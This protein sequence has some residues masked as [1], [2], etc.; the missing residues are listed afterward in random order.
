M[1]NELAL[2]YAYP[3]MRLEK[4]ADIRVEKAR[5]RIGVYVN[6]DALQISDLVPSVVADIP[7]WRNP[8]AYKLALFRQHSR[9][10]LSFNEG[11]VFVR[12]DEGNIQPATTERK[13]VTRY[14]PQEISDNRSM[15]IPT[16]R[17]STTRTH[18]E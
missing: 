10:G 9:N 14:R 1:V 8:Q 16:R 15:V 5:L 7:F 12:W 13:M 11:T 18:Q 6:Y 3:N 4:V 2:F 17:Y